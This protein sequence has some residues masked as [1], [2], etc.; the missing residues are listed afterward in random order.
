MILGFVACSGPGVA[1]EDRAEPLESRALG[2]AD[3]TAHVARTGVVAAE[4]ALFA[5]NYLRAAELLL[6]ELQRAEASVPLDS[7]VVADLCSRRANALRLGGRLRDGEALR[8]A[9]RSL[10]LRTM[11]FGAQSDE[12]AQSL[13]IL[14]RVQLTSGD[15][16]ASRQSL[17]TA[18][19]I[20]ESL[21]GPNARQTADALSDAGLLEITDRKPQAGLAYHTKALAIRE[22][23][24]AQPGPDLADSIRFATSLSGVGSA[25]VSVGSADSAHVYL[26]RALQ[27][28]KKLLGEDH[29][30]VAGTYYTLGNLG[31]LEG[32]TAQAR[33]DFAKSLELRRARFGSDHIDVAA[34]SNG[35]GLSLRKE[36]DLRGAI[37]YYEEALQICERVNGPDHPDLALYLNNIAGVY[38]TLGDAARA[39]PLQERSLAIRSKVLGPD[40]ADLGQTYQGLAILY[41]ELFRNREAADMFA[42]ATS[43]LEKALGADHPDVIRLVARRGLFELSQGR[44]AS[45]QALLERALR[46]GTQKLGPDHP[47]VGQIHFDFGHLLLGMGDPTG[48]LASYSKAQEIYRNSFGAAAPDVAYAR[49]GVGLAEATLGRFDAAIEKFVASEEAGRIQLR[50]VMDVLAEPDAL[51]FEQVRAEGMTFALG[52]LAQMKTRDPKLVRTVWESICRSRSVVL[53]ER[54]RLQREANSATEPHVVA[55]RKKMQEAQ[56][57][58]ARQIVASSFSSPEARDEKA[59]QLAR[60]TADAAERALSEASAIDREEISLAHWTWED[61]LGGLP[62]G[63]ALVSYAVRRAYIHQG[64]EGGYERGK[65]GAFVLTRA[66]AE[67]KFVSL[68]DQE[69]INDRVAA[70]HR[71]VQAGNDRGAGAALRR[72]IW[73]PIVAAAPELNGAKLVLVVPDG[74]LNLVTF[75]ALPAKSGKYFVEEGPTFHLLGTERDLLHLKEEMPTRRGLLALGDPNFDWRTSAGGDGA[76]SAAGTRAP[77]NLER[78]SGADCAELREIRWAR[79]PETGA[80]AEEIMN[81]WRKVRVG[82]ERGAAGADTRDPE[83]PASSESG[84]LLLLGDR[85]TEAN[86]KRFASRAERMHL[87]THGFFFD[88]ECRIAGGTKRGIGGLV[89]G[90]ATESKKI[91]HAASEA[92]PAKAAKSKGKKSA[93]APASSSRDRIDL[94]INPLSLSGLVLAGANAREE[95]MAGE[96]DGILTAEEV[97]TLDLR[98]VECV[99]LSACDTGVGEVM[100][101]EGVFGLRRA[102]RIAGAKTLVLSLWPVEDA[103]TRFWMREL[104]RETFADGASTAEAVRAASLR[105]LEWARKSGAST[106]PAT[107]GAFVASGAP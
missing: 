6:A 62:P 78:G 67:P 12:A 27:L 63:A 59:L 35:V 64:F 52:T 20:R 45:S 1:A 37:P 30:D 65:Y 5:G 16:A 60:E 107:W 97:A 17:E 101:S 75:A 90:S 54:A 84:D 26:D 7:S 15:R 68:G 53:D 50:R 106:S 73:D 85:A 98:G 39:L 31:L 92:S 80:E 41:E 33:V 46:D 61:L 58:L 69:E 102:F 43:V 22:A 105:T 51:A 13:G 95:T 38:Y 18:L 89:S 79:L 99:V 3:S 11:I 42:Q 55:L 28:R 8:L 44:Y 36:G 29:P 86:V 96:E 77:R 47:E 104:Y 25:Y 34:S 56:S 83:S 40:H 48:A 81:E 82:K 71:A 9:Q 76:T 91:T 49:M 19:K 2:A 94:G 14:G 74:A 93:V 103:S 24:L 87:A 21:F 66:Q 10:Q 100:A 57:E 72:A 4:S 23:L 88:G 70:W 32:N